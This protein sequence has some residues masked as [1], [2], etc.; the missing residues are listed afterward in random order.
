MKTTFCFPVSVNPD[1]SGSSACTATAI[2]KPA[3]H[4]SAI[5]KESWTDMFI[6]A[7]IGSSQFTNARQ[8]PFAALLPD[9]GTSP[10]PDWLPGPLA[11]TEIQH[12]DTIVRETRPAARFL[13]RRSSVGRAADS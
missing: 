4:T 10:A 7:A 6:I 11:F 1:A 9:Q 12:N 8:L 5:L 3:A 13:C 2:R